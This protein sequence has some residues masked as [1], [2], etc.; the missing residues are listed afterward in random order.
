MFRHIVHINSRWMIRF[1]YCLQNYWLECNSKSLV[2]IIN[3]RPW[4]MCIA[5]IGDVLERQFKFQ[6]YFS[7]ANWT[8]LFYRLISY[9]PNWSPLYVINP[10][11]LSC[12]IKWMV[13]KSGRILCSSIFVKEF[14]FPWMGKTDHADRLLLELWQSS[15][16][17]FN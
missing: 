9:T 12:F 14:K 15:A 2:G 3:K 4:K 17:E 8:H 7:R 13:L 1:S 5:F 16:N 6:F 10:L 11:K